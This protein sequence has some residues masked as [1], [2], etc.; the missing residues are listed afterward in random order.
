MLTQRD[1]LECQTWQYYGSSIRAGNDD[2]LFGQCLSYVCCK[3]FAQTRR[4]FAEL[5]C[6]L[7]LTQRSGFFW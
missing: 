2:S 3:A 6:Q 4:K 1:E 7:L 5:G